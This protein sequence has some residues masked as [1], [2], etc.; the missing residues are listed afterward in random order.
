MLTDGFL[1]LISEQSLGTLVPTGYRPVEFLAEDGIIGRIVKMAANR[2]VVRSAS[3]C[4]VTSRNVRTIR[5]SPAAPK[6]RASSASVLLPTENSRSISTARNSTGP[7]RESCFYG[8]QTAE[9]SHSAFPSLRIENALRLIP[10]NPEYVIEGPVRGLYLQFGVEHND[11]IN[12]RVEDCLRVFPFVDGLLDTCAEGRDIRECEHR[13]QNLA[14]A[15]GVGSYSRRRK[16]LS[17]SRVSI[18][19]GAPSAITRVQILFRSSTPARVLASEQPRSET[20]RPNT[21]MAARLMRATVRS[22][23]ITMIGTSTASST[24][25]SLAVIP[26][27]VVASP[28]AVPAT[29][30]SS[31]LARKYLCL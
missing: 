3:F 21:V 5:D 17:P 12:Y 2:E 10:R 22:R 16:R 9:V 4:S 1:C 13:A 19:C 7:E 23:L 31:S 6:R 29:K 14:I 25:I 28:D 30:V 8:F 18:R 11:G 27:E 26:P 20:F 15:S 24:P